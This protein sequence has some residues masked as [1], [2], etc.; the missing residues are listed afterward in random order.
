MDIDELDKKILNALIDDSRQ[1]Y[2]HIAKK[3]KVSVVTVMNRVKALER[4]KMIKKYTTLVNYE[5][6]GYGFLVIINARI[7]K[8]K[9]FDVE[10][11]LSLE[12]NI[13]AVYDV[14]GEFDIEIIAKFKNRQSL[15]GFVKRL[16][17]LEFVERTNTIL[18]LNSLKEE[19]IKVV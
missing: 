12:E 8:G 7:S 19:P 13:F 4:G 5:Q 1:S 14:T 16:Q 2:R 17:T 18:I 15:D 9:E 11:K 10:K 3:L 6:L